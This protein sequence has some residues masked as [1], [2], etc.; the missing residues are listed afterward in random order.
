MFTV[1]LVDPIPTVPNPLITKAELLLKSE[2]SNLSTGRVVPTPTLPSVVFA[3]NTVPLV[4]TLN[5]FLT[6]RKLISK[7]PKI[8]RSL[9]KV[10]IPVKYEVSPTNKSSFTLI[11][12]NSISLNFL[13]S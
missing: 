2:I 6:V 3:V 12:S 9:A 4:P 7:L 13:K 11:L 8:S 10:P 5:F 1:G